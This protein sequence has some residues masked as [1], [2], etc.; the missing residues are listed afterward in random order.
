M[1]SEGDVRKVAK[2]KDA[3]VYSGQLHR[4]YG[5]PLFGAASS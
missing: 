1:L 2:K 5:I 4:L 3:S